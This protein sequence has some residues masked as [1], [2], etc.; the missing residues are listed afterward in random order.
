MPLIPLHLSL[1]FIALV[2]VI[3]F[4]IVVTV[5]VYANRGPLPD[6]DKGKMVLTALLAVLAW[7]TFT[8]ILTQTGFLDDF[9][10][11]PPHILLVVVPPLAVIIF[12]LFSKK[13]MRLGTQVNQFWLVYPQSFRIVMEFIL[14]SL[15][16]YKCIPVQMTF[17]GMNFDILAGLT[18][19]FVAYYCFRK[20]TWPKWIGLVW[21][22]ISLGLLFNIVIVALLSTP[23]PFR[24]FMNEPA[25]TVIFYFPFVWLPGFVVPF[26][27]FLHL[28]SIRKL[29]ARPTA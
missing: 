3:A 17:E 13:F 11:M 19:P 14:W 21:N 12:L 9:Q 27:L 29:L 18:A 25:N 10:S 26:A 24:Q 8:L 16:R 15:Y 2:F 1:L 28:L 6:G 22:F 23:Y 5:S 4:F 7:L 20:Q